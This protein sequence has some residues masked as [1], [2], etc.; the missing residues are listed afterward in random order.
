MFASAPLHQSLP[1]HYLPSLLP[2]IFT[3]ANDMIIFTDHKVNVL[4]I[5]LVCNVLKTKMCIL[6]MQ[7][8]QDTS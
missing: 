4:N 7:D 8:I 6:Y 2:Q 5:S 3:H 1:N